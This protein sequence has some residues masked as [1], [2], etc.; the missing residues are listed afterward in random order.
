MTLT[1]FRMFHVDTELA[2]PLQNPI[3]HQILANT[4]NACTKRPCLPAT[5]AEAPAAPETAITKTS[6][7]MIF[8]P[9]GIF[10]NRPK[11]CIYHVGAH[12]SMIKNHFSYSISAVAG[13]NNFLVN[14]KLALLDEQVN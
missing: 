4:T 1:T 3:T 7:N 11:Q 8:P 9:S 5:T 2:K 14:A 13:L 10:R 12:Q 6:T